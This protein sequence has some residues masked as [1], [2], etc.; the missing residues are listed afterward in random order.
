MSNL[1]DKKLTEI[2]AGGDAH[3]EPDA[4]TT[5]AP[6]D[7]IKGRPDGGGGSGGG[8]G[9]GTPIEDDGSSSTPGQG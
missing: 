7:G 4:G 9:G 1:D 3:T 6:G 8:A 5:P 2:A